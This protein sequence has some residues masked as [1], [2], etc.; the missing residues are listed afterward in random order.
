MEAEAVESNVMYT[1]GS[2][3][4]EFAAE[5][6]YDLAENQAVGTARGI[7]GQIDVMV[8]VDG[9]S[10]ADVQVVYHHETLGIGTPAVEK[11]P[12]AIVEANSTAVDVVAGASVTSLAIEE[13][14][15]DAL[16]QLGFEG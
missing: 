6:S 4:K 14:A 12:P 7:G 3:S 16:E 2:G 8:T 13:A 15:A 10:I 5:R 11:I 1:A 9:G